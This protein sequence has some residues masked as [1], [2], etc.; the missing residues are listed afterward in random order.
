MDSIAWKK[1]LCPVDLTEDDGPV[2]EVA[3]DVARR[4][5]SSLVILHVAGGVDPQV[6]NGLD[7]LR[8]RAIAA[9]AAEVRTTVADGA[10]KST[11]AHYADEHGFGLVVMGTHGLT[12]RAHALAG[13]VAESTVRTAHCPVMVVH[14]A[15]QARAAQEAAA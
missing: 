11:I 3:A 9:G 5:G 7:A 1:I 14:P 4:L 10:P 2:V 12:G 8:E 6:V 15:W 13:S